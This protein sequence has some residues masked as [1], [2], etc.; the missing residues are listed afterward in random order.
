MFYLP[1]ESIIRVQRHILRKL[2]FSHAQ[3]THESGAG[4]VRS[5]V[6][7]V[8][9]SKP[10]ND[11]GNADEG[12]GMRGRANSSPVRGNSLDNTEDVENKRDEILE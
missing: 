10:I 9:N 11:I 5:R 4:V 1:L 7:H 2:G 3:S 8:E 6:P 12:K